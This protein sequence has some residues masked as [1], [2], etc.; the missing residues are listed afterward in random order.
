MF[1][2]SSLIF[3]H[4]QLEC[5]T[6]AYARNVDGFWQFDKVFLSFVKRS[7][8]ELSGYNN[9]TTTTNAIFSQLSMSFTG[10]KFKYKMLL[11]LCLWIDGE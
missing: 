9:Y 10:M 8:V 1:L 6:V 3:T 7:L 2:S 4:F 11:L 5:Q